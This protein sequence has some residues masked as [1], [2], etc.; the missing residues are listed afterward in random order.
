[1]AR[2]ALEAAREAAARAEAAQALEER[3]AG[4]EREL[5]RALAETTD[6]QSLVAE[7]EAD[8]GRLAEELAAVRAELA[9]QGAALEQ[10][11]A[12]LARLERTLLEKDRALEARNAR[13]ATLEQELE[14]K[15]AALQRLNALDLSLQSLDARMSERVRTP[16]PQSVAP[17][18]AP[19]LVC[20]TGDKPQ[21]YRLDKSVMTIGRSS[22]CDIQVLTHFISREHARLFVSQDGVVIEDLGSTNG[23][24]VN[25]V[26]VVRHLLT[27]S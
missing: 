1:A 3:A 12:D 26:R 18:S 14:E 23:V 16:E 15:I 4:L 8:R 11:G 27:H 2:K 10:A 22:Q 21:R 5:A 20:L 7:A 25:S 6:L 17:A 13:V 9:E 24:F 19:M